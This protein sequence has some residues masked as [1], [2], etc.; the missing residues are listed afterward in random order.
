[1]VSPLVIVYI[2]FSHWF[3]WQFAVVHLT[4]LC[5]FKGYMFNSSLYVSGP[6]FRPEAPCSFFLCG[7]MPG[8][9]GNASR[10]RTTTRQL[11]F[12]VL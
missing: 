12:V 2:P 6:M 3:T 8:R 1:M 11:H 5:R 4:F 10:R 7:T 9:E